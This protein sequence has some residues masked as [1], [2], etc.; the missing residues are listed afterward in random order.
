MATVTAR[1][2]LAPFIMQGIAGMFS[3]IKIYYQPISFHPY[4]TIVKK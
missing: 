2:V 3:A 4:Q 1:H